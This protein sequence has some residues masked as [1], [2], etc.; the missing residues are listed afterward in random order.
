MR[1]FL[2]F[3][4]EKE[5]YIALGALLVSIIFIK[6]FNL[7][8]I[9]ENSFLENMQLLALFGG[10][11]ATLKT[12]NYK[13]FFTFLALVLI[14][15]FAREISYG[16][17]FIDENVINFNKKLCHI[18]VGIYIGLS[19]L[20]ALIKK[21]WV[22]IISIIKNIKFPFW[23]F[24]ASFGCVLVQILSEKYLHNTCIEETA[25]FML[26]CLILSLI[27]IYRKK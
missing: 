9:E 17:V 7:E 23:T 13:T 18:I 12:K 26:Y 14:L 10:F 1:K 16:R 3:K 24:F 4:F 19:V 15:M 8:S 11:V 5:N 22:D 25:E 20:Y 6:I 27:L 2:D 21:I